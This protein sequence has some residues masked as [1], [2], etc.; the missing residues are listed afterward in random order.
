[1][2]QLSLERNFLK[3]NFP[4]DYKQREIN[5]R[6]LDEKRFKHLIELKPAT[7]YSKEIISLG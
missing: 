5:N 3:N 6:K 2:I 1:M 4:K 7:K